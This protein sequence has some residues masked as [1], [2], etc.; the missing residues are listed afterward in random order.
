M[1]DYAF[2]ITQD[3]VENVLA[4]HNVSYDDATMDDIMAAI[5]D[6]EISYAALCV[7]VD[8]DDDDDDVLEKQTE[9]AYDEIAWQLY[10]GGFIQEWQI[11]KYGNKDLLSRIPS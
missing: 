2:Q 9:A 3:D 1:S 10:Q 4:S 6:G 11:E 8:L 7:D 5:D